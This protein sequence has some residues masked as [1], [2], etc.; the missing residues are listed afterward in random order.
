MDRGARQA[1]VHGVAKI[2]TR[3]KWLNNNKK[4]ITNSQNSN[5]TS[6][7][8]K[9]LLTM[10][11]SRGEFESSVLDQKKE[12]SQEVSWRENVFAIS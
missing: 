2:Q 12:A 9:G 1:I 3:L 10:I 11:S 7:N 5:P 8:V 6:M 4:L